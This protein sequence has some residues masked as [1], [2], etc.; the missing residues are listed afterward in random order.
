ME[1][2][3]VEFFTWMMTSPLFPGSVAEIITHAVEGVVRRVQETMRTT[4]MVKH[5]MVFNLS[6]EKLLEIFEDLSSKGMFLS[7]TKLRIKEDLTA[8]IGDETRASAVLEG[9][10]PSTPWPEFLVWAGDR[11]VA[12]DRAA[13]EKHSRERI[14]VAAAVITPIILKMLA[15][16]KVTDVPIELPFVDERSP[17]E[18]IIASPVNFKLH[19][20][21][22]P[23]IA[24]A[25]K[26]AENFLTLNWI[27]IGLNGGTVFVKPDRAKLAE[28]FFSGIWPHSDGGSQQRIQSAAIVHKVTL[29]VPHLEAA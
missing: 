17:F 27:D 8:I 3:M 5:G 7:L 16:H 6:P 23:L 2:A 29:P 25:P 11:F 10:R 12:A 28:E 1:M 24:S 26:S 15:N 20:R 14:D 13:A 21:A 4:G 22:T 9:T 19:H 18:G